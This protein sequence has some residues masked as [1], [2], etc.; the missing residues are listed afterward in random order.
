MTKKTEV[1]DGVP[2]EKTP[3]EILKEEEEYLLGLGLSPEKISVETT[4]KNNFDEGILRRTLSA[5]LNVYRGREILR[6][7]CVIKIPI[8]IF[9]IAKAK[10]NSNTPK[11][12][13]VQ[14]VY[15]FLQ[16]EAGEWKENGIGK[17]L[18]VPKKIVK[19]NGGK[20]KEIPEFSIAGG[21]PSFRFEKIG[22]N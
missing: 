19:I 22:F 16:K 5:Y 6:R 10:T 2:V 4:E 11:Q 15:D 17:K 12:K 7:D 21:V 18:T 3:E 1:L 8:S 20:T 13:A 9:E 14:F